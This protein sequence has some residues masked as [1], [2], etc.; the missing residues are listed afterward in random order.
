MI[1]L[2]L[3]SRN[4]SLHF[5]NRRFPCPL[6]RSKQS[7]FQGKFL[8]FLTSFAMYSSSNFSLSA[9]IN[10]LQRWFKQ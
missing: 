9:G 7:D 5:Q 8:R 3:N 2:R 10:C 4:L 1:P 6:I